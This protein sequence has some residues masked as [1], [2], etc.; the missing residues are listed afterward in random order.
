[1]FGPQYFYN[2]LSLVAGSLYNLMLQTVHHVSYEWGVLDSLAARSLNL[3]GLWYG[4]LLTVALS[5]ITYIG[6]MRH[7]RKMHEEL[8]EHIDRRTSSRNPGKKV[9]EDPDPL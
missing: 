2:M 6:T 9:R 8:R 1:M 5:F 3:A 7:M 4:P